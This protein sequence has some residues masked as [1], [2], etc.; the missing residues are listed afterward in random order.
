MQKI[1]YLK[2][3][4]L[5]MLLFGSSCSKDEEPAA[6]ITVSADNL[7]V[8]NDDTDVK[9][10]VTSDVDWICTLRPGAAFVLSPA[11]GNA[12]TTEV[13]VSA[14]P[15]TAVEERI[16]E[17]VISG[18]GYA[19]TVTL[20]QKSTGRYADGGSRVYCKSKMEHPVKLIITGDGYLPEHFVYGG[21]FDQNADEA[22]EALFSVEP[23]KTYREYFSVYKVAAYSSEV[24]ISNKELGITKNTVF[25]SVMDGGYGTGIE[26]D[27][28]KVFEYAVKPADIQKDDLYNTSVCVIINADVYA[29]TC[30]TLSNGR[31]IAMVPV[32]RDDLYIK[33]F[34]NIICHEYGGHGFGRLADEYASYDE[35]IPEDR[36]ED[37]LVWQNNYGYYLNVSPYSTDWEVP[38]SLFIGKPDYP[39]V[40]IYQGGYLYMQGITRSEQISCMEDNRLYFNTISRY[41]IADRILYIAGEVGE[42]FLSYEKFLEKDVQKG[43][44]AEPGMLYNAPRRAFVPLA[45]PILVDVGAPKERR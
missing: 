26:C 45:P 3:F 9:L 10:T 32:S 5:G 18:G 13:S 20:T 31:S 30:Y 15:N 2:V 37:L 6:L 22:I 1:L 25:S 36:K 41:L 16:S 8:P 21:L 29:G 42:Q 11:S 7:S 12:G 27:Y 14:S 34:K 19:V 35:V 4:L 23:Y 39:H 17:L 38:W 33:N 40:G 44:V 43:P 28:D 24:G